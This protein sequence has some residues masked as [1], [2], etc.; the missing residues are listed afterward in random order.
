MG[1]HRYQSSA[2]SRSARW[3]NL[4]VLL[5]DTNVWLAAADRRSNRH[6]ECLELLQVRRGELASTVPVISETG[7]LLLDRDGPHAQQQ[8]LASIV[9]GDI[10]VLDLGA[11]DWARVVELCHADADLGLDLIDASTIAVAERLKLNTIATLDRRDFTVVRP[12]HT[13]S[14]EL[15]PGPA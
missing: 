8:F 3:L 6:N 2:Q 14:F 15:L 11:A 7:W 1:E 12:S 9:S 4:A 5:V 10:D 13:D